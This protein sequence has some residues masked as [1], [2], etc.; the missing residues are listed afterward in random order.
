MVKFSFCRMQIIR[1]LGGIL[2][3]FSHCS[4]LINTPVAGKAG[5][6]NVLSVAHVGSTNSKLN[7]LWL[8]RLFDSIE[9]NR[10]KKPFSI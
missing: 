10:V 6:E 7:Q 2:A 9:L 4:I 5:G 1:H 8:Y 3:P